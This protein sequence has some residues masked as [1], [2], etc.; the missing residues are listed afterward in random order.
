MTTQEKLKRITELLTEAEKLIDEAELLKS[1]VEKG[2]DGDVL[3][4]DKEYK[5][6]YFE[7]LNYNSCIENLLY[8]RKNDKRDI[9]W[10]AEREQCG[11]WD[12]RCMWD[13]AIFVTEHIYIW[14]K[15]L[16]DHDDLSFSLDHSKICIDGEEIFIRNAVLKIIGYIECF[17]TTCDTI[18]GRIMEGSETII[19]EA[20]R[21]L[22]IILPYLGD[23][24]YV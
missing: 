19:A 10:K 18:N 9:Y 2:K 21:V 17:L 14:L 22:G 6:K 16:L 7:E 3:N 5:N 13:F 15:I 8:K 20:Y 23:M 11:G 12:E 4:E 24:K 1:E